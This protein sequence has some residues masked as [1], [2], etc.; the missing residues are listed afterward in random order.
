[1]CPRPQ[2]RRRIRGNP[3]CLYFKPQGIPIRE[4]EE[5]EL[6]L[7]EFEALRLIDFL[8]TEQKQAAEKMQISQPTLS[9]VLKSGRR[10]IS[11]AIIQS[12]SIKIKKR[13]ITE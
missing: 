12:K 11:E 5:I 1:M 3:N 2:I 13:G 9:R 7:A 6:S 4:L 8:G 10:K